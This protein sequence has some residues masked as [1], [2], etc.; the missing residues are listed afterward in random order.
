MRN[1]RIRVGFVAAFAAAALVAC[2]GGG[3]S[4]SSANVRLINA[5]LTHASLSL[6][7]NATS[8]ITADPV[9]TASAYVG[10][11][12]GSPTLQIND[13]T[14]GAVL[15]TTAPTVAGNQH[16]ALVAYESGGNV[17]T[18][19]IAEDTTAPATGTASLRIFDTATDAGAIDVYV[20]DPA[21]DITT[22]SSP[23]FAFVS[24]T[25]VQASAFLSFGPGTYRIR[26]TGSG[27]PS[28][29][30]L[31]IASVVLT[32]QEVATAIITP[33]TGGTL[34]N[35]AVLVQQGAYTASRNTNS[36]VRLAVAVSSNATVTA[37]AGGI[38]IGTGTGTG[39]VA[40]A[41]GAYTNVPAGS[42]IN[43]SVN[44]S[45]IGA[46]ATALTAG[47]DT[48]LLVYGNAGS[49]VASLIADDNHL[50]AVTTN[51]KMRLLNGVT[52][53]AVPLS[54]DINFAV[55]ASSIA[56]GA[57]SSYAV[58]PAGT[59]GTL[60]HFDVTSPSSLTPI[61]TANIPIPGNSVFTLFMLGDASAPI[62][63]LRKDR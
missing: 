16:F 36:R 20:T 59:A 11:S 3:S 9:D 28:D 19:V 58:V 53:A 27:N 38:S 24:S 40:P 8:A 47:S 15:A 37:A 34:A 30:R 29:L 42:A 50:P 33:T 55:V 4:S 17:R 60:T 61:Y 1:F 35:G 32:N 63:L 57:A 31:D 14:S 45:S 62:P 21:V 56:P 5:T 54:L 18:A 43:I 23:T 12:A 49:A 52:G 6:L 26:V 41:I 51:F 46:P 39:V 48:T 25:S 7:A 22:L 13:A 10:V 44:G 2:G